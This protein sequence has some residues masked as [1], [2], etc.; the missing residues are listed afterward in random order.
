MKMTQP[1][2]KP[3]RSK[4]WYWRHMLPKSAFIWTFILASAVLVLTFGRAWRVEVAIAL[5]VAGLAAIFQ[6]SAACHAKVSHFLECFAR[7]NEAYAKL[8]GLLRQPSPSTRACNGLAAD[9]GPDDAIIDYFNLCAEE[10]VMQKMGVIPDFVW[11][12]WR[13]GI[14]DRALKEHILNGW[15]KE[16]KAKC[17]YYGFDLEQTILEHH[18]AHGRECEK[19]DNCPLGQVIAR[20]SLTAAR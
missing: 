4:N 2:L 16:K 17:D 9:D 10:Y 11:D 3:E 19:R 18:K 8:N 15:D 14:H 7:C 6:I 20:A 5:L 12:V 13:A 1:K